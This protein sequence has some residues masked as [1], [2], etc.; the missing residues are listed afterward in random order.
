MRRFLRICMAVVTAP[1]IPVLLSVLYVEVMKFP[2]DIMLIP[3][4]LAMLVFSYIS[5]FIFG[6]LGYIF[7]CHRRLYKL[8]SYLIVGAIGGI[9]EI[10]S[11]TL[12]AHHS[13]VVM[14]MRYFT[15]VILFASAGALCASSFWLIVRPDKN[16]RILS[17][18]R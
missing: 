15:G 12:L 2:E 6:L 14:T 4:F 17:H 8:R 1:I 7:L 13:L 10:V 3:S 16:V 11:L 5:A 18:D 9:I